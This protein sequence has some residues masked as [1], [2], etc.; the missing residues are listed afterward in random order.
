MF[1]S[2]FSSVNATLPIKTGVAYK[3]KAQEYIV[4]K[5]KVGLSN[6][7]FAEVKLRYSYGKYILS[8]V[9]IV[10]HLEENNISISDW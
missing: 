10:Y 6:H 9:I 7:M 1:Y 8:R 5:L 3:L 2:K 4:Q